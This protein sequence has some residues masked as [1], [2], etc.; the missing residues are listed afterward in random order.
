MKFL[1]KNNKELLIGSY[2]VWTPV[3]NPYGAVYGPIRK[4]FKYPT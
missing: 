3:K 2:I 4:F 1:D